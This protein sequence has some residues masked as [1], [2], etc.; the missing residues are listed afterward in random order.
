MEF[1]PHLYLRSNSD[2]ALYAAI[3]AVSYINFFRRSDQLLLQD[4]ISASN[5]YAQALVRVQDELQSNPT[6]D[7]LLIAVYLMG[8]YEVSS[9][10]CFHSTGEV[11]RYLRC[12]STDDGR[13]RG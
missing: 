12:F 5:H 8:I 1:V 10:S 11:S 3:A 7:S 4:K 2:S 9:P 13:E 6:S